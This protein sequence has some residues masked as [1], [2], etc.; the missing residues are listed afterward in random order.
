M[1]ELSSSVVP[2]RE[3]F[4]GFFQIHP[5]AAVSCGLL[6]ISSLPLRIALPR[7]NA[8][9]QSVCVIFLFSARCPPIFSSSPFVLVVM[10]VVG[11]VIAMS[12][13]GFKAREPI[14][15]IS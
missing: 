2:S 3:R 1:F 11:P 9:P 13:L 5:R 6:N 10:V 7:G 4:I 8:S 15:L 12:V 14:F